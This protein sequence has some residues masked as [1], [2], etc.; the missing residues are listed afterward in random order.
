MSVSIL[1]QNL[2]SKGY[3]AGIV[4]GKLGALTFQALAEFATANVAP[5]GTGDLLALA[6][7]KV[8]SQRREYTH[9]FAQVAHESGFKP[10]SENLN[11]SADGLRATFSK[12]RISDGQCQQFGRTAGHAADRT[13]I[14]NTVYGGV[15]GA[16]HLGNTKPG[17]GY[18]FRGRGLIQL[19]GRE[20]YA[21]LGQS[22]ETNPDL[23]LTPAGSVS[24]AVDFWTT[25][26]IEAPALADD[27]V[28]VTKL[29]N[30]GLKGLP[31][32]KA[33]TDKIKAIWPE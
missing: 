8:M 12:E 10:Q 3:D 27:I 26:S 2:I 23:L 24:A 30:G 1:Q 33:L 9:F 28:K 17:D 22:Y 14:G 15:W 20:N 25:R 7:P 13:S 18:L 29:I 5:M 11:Y 21:H 31:E 16:N 32:R 4:D 19:T 6:L